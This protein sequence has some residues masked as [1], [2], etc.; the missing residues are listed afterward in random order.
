ME[1][2]KVTNKK[3]DASNKILSD[4]KHYDNIVIQDEQL[5]KWQKSVHGRKVQHS[6]LG[7]IKSKLMA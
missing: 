4:L 1:Y 2:Q 5:A 6:I 3:N 7:R